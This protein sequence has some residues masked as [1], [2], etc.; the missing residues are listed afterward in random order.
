MKRRLI[1][2]ICCLALI[3]SFSVANAAEPSSESRRENAG[4]A[5]AQVKMDNP[6]R[7]ADYD[8]DREATKS[9]RFQLLE[10][11]IIQKLQKQYQHMEAPAGFEDV[12]E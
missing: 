3:L 2:Q 11:L 8:Q 9:E 10:W 12:L 7:T 4:K 5:Q 6:G 1:I